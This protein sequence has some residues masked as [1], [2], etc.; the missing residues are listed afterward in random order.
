MD[1]DKLY[2]SQTHEWLEAAGEIATVGITRFAVDQLTD[3]VFVELPPI[4]KKLS[5]GA[6]FG[7]VESVKHVSDLYAP[8]GGEVVEINSAV[9]SDPAIL[10]KDPYELGWLI[11]LRLEDRS[12]VGRLMSKGD[13]DA[14]C[15][16]H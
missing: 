13:Y 10:S 5:A 15:Q 9:V 4:G 7:I 6:T 16:A 1:L 8:A 3:L 14:M 11:K 2:Y 12:Q